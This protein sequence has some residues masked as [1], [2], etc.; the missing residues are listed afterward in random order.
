MQRKLRILLSVVSM[1]V[2]LKSMCITWQ[3]PITKDVLAKAFSNSV[4]FLKIAIHFACSSMWA[5]QTSVVFKQ[6]HFLEQVLQI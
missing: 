6:K 5:K 2:I 4:E 1:L 3:V